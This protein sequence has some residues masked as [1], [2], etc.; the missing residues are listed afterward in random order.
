MTVSTF[1]QPDYTVD[2]ATEYKTNIDAAVAVVSNVAADF[3]PH[4]A[5]TPNMTVLIDAGKLYA[6]GTLTEQ[7]QQTSATITAPTTNPRIDRIVI[8]GSTGA[9]SVI[10]GAEAAS[11]T[12]PA[13]TDGAIPIAQI[14]LAIS[15]TAITDSLIT[16]ER[17]LFFSVA[18]YAKIDAAETITGDWTFAGALSG[19]DI[20][21]NGVG[22]QIGSPTGG[23]KGA[24]TVN[25]AGGVYDNG[26]QLA[27]PTTVTGYYSAQNITID[28]AGGS[29]ASFSLGSYIGAAWESVGPT[30]SGAANIW[31]AL[32]A[33]PSTAT[34]LLLKAYLS[35]TGS[36]NGTTYQQLLYAR[37]TGSGLATSNST[38]A[39]ANAFT[40]RS[41]AS[42]L[43]QAVSVFPIAIDSSLRFDLYFIISGSPSPSISSLSLV[44][45]IE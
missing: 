28:N 10:T 11:P 3:A 21:D 41:G 12:A 34:G 7:T 5:A 15:T 36:T 6:D 39:A 25:I 20:S 30:G 40:N 44:G 32:D 2:T 17:A 45:W 33:V 8:D 37:R 26:T 22:V 19:Q 9:V 23:A 38:V 42:Q 43:G 31:T 24:G 16:D 1:N 13:F 4:E 29:T 27:A 18:D 35:A 14:L